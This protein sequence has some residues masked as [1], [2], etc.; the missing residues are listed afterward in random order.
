MM[1]IEHMRAIFL[2]I[3]GGS[4]HNAGAYLE[5][6]DGSGHGSFSRARR[7]EAAALAELGA[8]CSPLKASAAGAAGAEA[9]ALAEPPK[10]FLFNA[11]A[12][13]S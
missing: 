11:S 7:P 10:G 13:A 2:T 9:A 4:L 1:C 6:A 3:G 12:F 8:G 5:V